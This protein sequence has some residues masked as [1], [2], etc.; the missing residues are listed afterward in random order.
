M[1]I[2]STVFIFLL[3]CFTNNSFGQAVSV[4]KNFVKIASTQTGVAS[5]IDTV[6]IN[7]TGF[8]NGMKL[9]VPF[10]FQVSIAGLSFSDSLT[11]P[12]SLSGTTFP[13]YIRTLP[14]QNDQTFR[15]DLSFYD[16]VNPLSERIYLIGNSINVNQSISTCTWNI[17][18]FG[19]PNYCNC[20]TNLSRTN[21]TTIL[22][23]LEADVI[24]LQEIVSVEQLKQVV[25]DMGPQYAYVMAPYSSQ[26]QSSSTVA[27]QTA[28][29]QAYI[30]NA[31]KLQFFGDSG[32]L[33][34]TYPSQLGSSSPYYYFASGRW[35]YGLK[36]KVISTGET[37]HFYNIHGKAFSG[38]TEHNRRAG[39]A[40]KMTD[41]LNSTLPNSKIVVLG[42]FNDLLEGAIS[43]GFSL[44]PYS[45]MLTNGFTGI[46][47]PSAFPGETTYLGSTASLIDNY[48]VSQRALGAYIPNSAIILREADW[49]IPSFK[50][51]T[52][53]H[54]PVLANFST[55]LT[56]DIED[57]KKVDQFSVRNNLSNELLIEGKIE[58]ERT[59]EIY[60]IDGKLLRTMQFAAYEKMRKSLNNFSSG[61]YI[62]K[63]GANQYYET[64]KLLIP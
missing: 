58:S 59:L 40:L 64:H 53:D 15:G 60:S 28:Q 16:G 35:P 62:L 61:I 26:I 37:F 52:S 55:S 18:W 54:L 51:T 63:V 8:S 31:Q 19:L 1:T 3:F 24:A 46:T 42:D 50:S 36:L 48:A 33:S 27:Y 20:D 45:Y 25:W 21:V 44:S 57:I 43:T 7:F 22:K 29:K 10:P 32:L 14:N 47:L 9:V 23:E 56:T 34:N 13:I 2:R 49:A 5:A 38:S 6:D 41:E 30:Y 4:Q 12:Q 39:G 17:K 11:V